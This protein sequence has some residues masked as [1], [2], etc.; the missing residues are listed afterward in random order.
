M[1]LRVNLVWSD[2][3]EECWFTACGLIHSESWFWWVLPI[4]IEPA[5]W[6]CT[7]LGGKSSN[8]I[9]VGSFPCSGGPPA[10]QA[11]PS[12][13]KPVSPH[14][15]L[16]RRKVYSLQDIMATPV[17]LPI[18]PCGTSSPLSCCRLTGCPAPGW[19][20]L[21]YV[22]QTSK[23]IAHIAPEAASPAP[24]LS[25]GESS[26]TLLG[27]H[28][29]SSAS[30]CKSCGDVRPKNGQTSWCQVSGVMTSPIWPS[31]IKP[32]SLLLAIMLTVKQEDKGDDAQHPHTASIWTV[33]FC[34][35]LSQ[36]TMFSWELHL[37]PPITSL[38][39]QLLPLQPVDSGLG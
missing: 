12:H 13:I 8:G 17:L 36:A 21:W 26:Q 20:L 37:L 7:V 2:V 35:A 5:S 24:T 23:V 30:P 4:E 39:V 32:L 11:S 27:V 14:H 16:V 1:W 33:K 29:A 34:G 15:W 6:L 25:Q 38:V 3:S 19:F 31:P 10:V 22:W 18:I 28:A 9:P